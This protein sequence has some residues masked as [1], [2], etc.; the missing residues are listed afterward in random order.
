MFKSAR[1]AYDRE[2]KDKKVLTW[3]AKISI[4]ENPGIAVPPGCK[5]GALHEKKPLLKHISN[6]GTMHEHF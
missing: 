5:E 3:V 4:L 2:R 1:Y 6:F